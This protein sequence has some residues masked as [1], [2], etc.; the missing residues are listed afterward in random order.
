MLLIENRSHLSIL[1]RIPCRQRRCLTED[2]L[3]ALSDN[4]FIRIGYKEFTYL[5]DHLFGPG[6]PQLRLLYASVDED[7]A[8]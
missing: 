5:V 1:I 6:L 2:V 8:V 7:H 3:A 4:R